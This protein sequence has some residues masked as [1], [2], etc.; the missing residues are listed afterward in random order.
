MIEN[1]QKLS[2]QINKR[3]FFEIFSSIS[4][5]SFIDSFIPSSVSIG[6]PLFAFC[7]ELPNL[8]RICPKKKWVCIPSIHPSVHSSIDLFIHF[9]LIHPSVYHVFLQFFCS[10]SFSICVFFSEEFISN[11]PISPIVVFPSSIGQSQRCEAWDQ[12]F[13]PWC[14]GCPRDR[15]GIQRRSQWRIPKSFR[16]ERIGY[17][18]SIAGESARSSEDGRWYPRSCDRWIHEDS[19]RRRRDG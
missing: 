10:W 6:F 4:D 16:A 19:F 9:Y 7:S 13:P 18:E 15:N 1:H 11:F 2:K 14:R 5:R 17:A 3:Q 12:S 8:W